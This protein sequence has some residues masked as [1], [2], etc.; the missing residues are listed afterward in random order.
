MTKMQGWIVIGILAI[1][2]VVGITSYIFSNIATH[3]AV[4]NAGAV[5]IE[6]CLNTYA[7]G[8]I[9]SSNY[10]KTNECTH[11]CEAKYALPITNISSGAQSGQ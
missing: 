7:V 4:S 2:L 5:C 8:G 9:N 6:T 1:A 11:Q 3:K 10:D